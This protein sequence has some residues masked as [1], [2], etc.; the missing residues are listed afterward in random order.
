MK[1]NTNVMLENAKKLSMDVDVRD[2]GVYIRFENF[3][4]TLAF[5]NNVYVSKLEDTEKS[6]W[7]NATGS[8][9]GDMTKVVYDSNDDGVVDRT[10]C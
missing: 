7:V 10:C 4:I 6:V 1:L 2:L 3:K 5:M 9:T 8:G